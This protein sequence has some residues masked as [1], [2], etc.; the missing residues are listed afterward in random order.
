MSSVTKKYLYADLTWPEVNEAVAARKV[1]LLPVGS[2][3]Q[4]GPH[5]P[6]DTDNLI[7]A[8][9]TLE[10]GRRAPDKILVAPAIPYG[11][12]VHAMDYPGT[13][14]IAYQ[15][16]IDYC[17]DT[18]KSFIYH[19]FKRII[20]VNGHGGNSSSLDLAARRTVLETD[21]LVT[22]FMWWDMLSVDA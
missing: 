21:G 14:H 5:L 20:I 9:V 6:L 13:M 4:H 17:V 10:A 8:G 12:N 1:I 2:T 7:A 18:C 22:A 19:G 16:F 15:H 3:E 11:Y